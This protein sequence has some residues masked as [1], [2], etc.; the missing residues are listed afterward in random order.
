MV[1]LN[2]AA[3]LLTLIEGELFGREKGAYT[4]ALTKEVGRLE[5]ANHSTIFLDE[6]SE[7]PSELQVKLLRILQ[8]GEFERLAAPRHCMSMCG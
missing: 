3:L 7:L 5:L 8:E 4:D 6:I 1:K 2:C